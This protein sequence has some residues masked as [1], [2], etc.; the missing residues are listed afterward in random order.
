MEYTVSGH[1]FSRARSAETWRGHR[2]VRYNGKIRRKGGLRRLSAAEVEKTM[3]HISWRKP[4]AALIFTSI[5]LF[6]WA[7]RPSD[8]VDTAL[9]RLIPQAHWDAAG[10]NKLTVPEQHALAGEISGLLGQ[11]GSPA[12]T[13]RSQWRQLH[14]HMSQDDVRKLLGEPARVSV[15]RFYEEWDYPRGNLIFDGKG[16]LDSWSEL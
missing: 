2:E 15:S 9:D 14:R 12:Q 7:S 4:A 16:R 1:G 13:D 5:A 8:A 3:I 11:T 6:A 10:L